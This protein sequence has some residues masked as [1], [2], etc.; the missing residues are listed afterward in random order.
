MPIGDSAEGGVGSLGELTAAP[1]GGG[2]PGAN[3]RVPQVFGFPNS[4]TD[5]NALPSSME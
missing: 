5:V 2:V 1:P 4:E 3:Q